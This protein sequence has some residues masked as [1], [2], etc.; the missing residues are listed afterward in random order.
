MLSSYERRLILFYL[1]NVVPHLRGRDEE[2][3]NLLLWFSQ[4]EDQLGLPYLLREDDE[5]ER[6]LTEG[7]R[8]QDV[9]ARVWQRLGVCRI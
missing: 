6:V 8:D 2:A 4:H 1:A 3:K 5:A 9:P 7:L